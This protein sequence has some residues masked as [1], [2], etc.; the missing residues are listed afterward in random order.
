MTSK[1]IKKFKFGYCEVAIWEN[2]VNEDGKKMK[3]IS[4]VQKSY[5]DSNGDWKT[6]TNLNPNDLPHA[7]MCFQEALKFV[8]ERTE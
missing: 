7:I 2:T 3:S 1:P 5:K 4:T 6:T 8:S